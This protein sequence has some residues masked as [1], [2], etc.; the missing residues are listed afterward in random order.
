MPTTAK[1]IAFAE[2]LIRFSFFL[3]FPL[4]LGFIFFCFARQSILALLLRSINAVVAMQSFVFIHTIWF[5]P[6]TAFNFPFSIHCRP[7]SFPRCSLC[8][9]CTLGHC[10]F[11]CLLLLSMRIESK[12]ICVLYF[13]CFHLARRFVHCFYCGLHFHLTCYFVF[14]SVLQSYPPLHSLF[15]LPLWFS[16]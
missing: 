14:G 16:G 11:Y 8:P 5:I 6:C 2:I 3:L 12:F 7:F 4:F 1:S 15:P 9:S 10:F 13:S